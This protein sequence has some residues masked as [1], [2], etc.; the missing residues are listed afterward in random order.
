MAGLLALAGAELLGSINGIR[1]MPGA[2]SGVGV[3]R[4]YISKAGL[5]QPEDSR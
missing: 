1:N 5:A 2:F 4:L 3:C